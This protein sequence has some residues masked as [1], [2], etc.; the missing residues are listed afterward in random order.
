MKSISSIAVAIAVLMVPALAG[1]AFAQAEAHKA[2]ISYEQLGNLKL[3]EP[4]RRT[5]VLPA[6]SPRS[7]IAQPR[8]YVHSE[9]ALLRIVPNAKGNGGCYAAD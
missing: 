6:H 3:K 8:V 1:I 5:E 9:G 7:W 2:A 4:P